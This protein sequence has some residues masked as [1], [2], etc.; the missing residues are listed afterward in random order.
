MSDQVPSQGFGTGGANG[1]GL[2]IATFSALT[3]A[4]SGSTFFSVTSGLATLGVGL[5]PNVDGTLPLGGVGNRW[6]IVHTNAAT[7]YGV[8]GLTVA[9]PNHIISVSPAATDFAGASVG[10]LT[11]APAAGNPTKWINIT[12][13]GVQRKI[14]CW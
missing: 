14:P 11:N 5:F 8:N 7:V 2:I 13:G 4:V 10:T 3:V 1:I 12:D 9:D 6:S